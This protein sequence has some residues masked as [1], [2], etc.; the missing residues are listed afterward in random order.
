MIILLH[1]VS[2]LASVGWTTYAFFAPSNIKL[3]ISYALFGSTVASGTYLVLYSSG[4][5]L[6]TC[7]TG[8]VYIGV[9]SLGLVAIHRKVATITAKIRK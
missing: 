3:Y 4:H 1:V 6:Q 9:V 2:A 8:L 5:L 7:V